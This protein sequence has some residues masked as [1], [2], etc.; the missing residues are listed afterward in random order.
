MAD[1]Q[2]QPIAW[3]WPNRIAC[4]KLTLVAGDPGLGKSLATLDIAARV[5]TGTAWPDGATA[6]EPGGVILL[7]AEDDP[8]DTIRP[9]LD[10]AGADVSRTQLLR[11]V[12]RSEKSSE[13]RFSLDGDLPMLEFA[14]TRTPNAKLVIIDPISAYLGCRVDSYVNSEVRSL[15]APL[16][17][18]AGRTGVAIVLVTHLSKGGG[19]KAVYRAMGSLAFAAAARCVWLFAADRQDAKRRLFLSAKSNI[20][21][22]TPG[23]AYT[24]ENGE[25]GPVVAWSAEPVTI[26]ADEALADPSG[27]GGDP[28]SLDSAKEWLRDSLAAGPMPADDVQAGA[29]AEGISRRTLS[30]AKSEL[31]V[32]SIRQGYGQGSRWVWSLPGG[33]DAESAAAGAEVPKDAKPP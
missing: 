9:R 21:P 8:A 20:A 2:P 29:K 18:L 24:I 32:K 14:I 33:V 6:C 28:S 19:G 22:D 17:E 12:R 16:A 25:G 15:L 1:V 13:S 10:A 11:A 31:G 30:R 7:S 26:T 3:L 23:M 4:G 5:T 27:F